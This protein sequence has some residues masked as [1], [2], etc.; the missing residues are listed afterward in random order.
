MKVTGER[1]LALRQMALVLAEPQ[2]NFRSI[3]A[4]PALQNPFKFHLGCERVNCILLVERKGIGYWLM[5]FLTQVKHFFCRCPHTS[6][7]MICCSPFKL[8]LGQGLL[9]SKVL[10]PFWK[11]S[12]HL[13]VR[14]EG[15]FVYL[16][17]WENFGIK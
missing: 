9:Q 7:Y 11:G 13:R 2:Q 14:Q 6:P 15:D 1:R 8:G 12:R 10:K 4:G 5:V 16:F 17:I 3:R